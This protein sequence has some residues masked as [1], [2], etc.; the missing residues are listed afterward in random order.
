[1]T[2]P[3]SEIID[4]RQK[5]YLIAIRLAKIGI[6]NK[7]KA[8]NFLML[9]SKI[10]AEG[11]KGKV[12]EIIDSYKNTVY[13][14]RSQNDLINDLKQLC[15]TWDKSLIDSSLRFFNSELF[16]Y[17]CLKLIDNK[18]DFTTIKKMIVNRDFYQEYFLTNFYC[19]CNRLKSYQHT[20]IFKEYYENL[21]ILLTQIEP[22]SWEIKKNLYENLPEQSYESEIKKLVLLIRGE[23]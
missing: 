10:T 21:N 9:F 7:N 20:E 16:A 17:S 18:K 2:K 13:N 23:K 12:G 22:L 6:S 3:E 14:S 11:N 15:N 5:E 19:T 1:M 8:L 4:K